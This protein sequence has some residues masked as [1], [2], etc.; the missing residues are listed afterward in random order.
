MK[1]HSLA[2]DST[3]AFNADALNRQCSNIRQRALITLIT[4]IA[5][6]LVF[7]SNNALYADETRARA[8]RSFSLVS[9]EINKLRSSAATG[10]SDTRQVMKMVQ[11]NDDAL[12][13]STAS[14]VELI[15]NA[16]STTSS[17]SQRSSSQNRRCTADIYFCNPV[18]S[19]FSA[20]DW[21]PRVY[22]RYRRRAPDIQ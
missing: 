15:G 3:R 5:I 20:L 9:D 8:T 10:E 2:V 4:L 7:F 22:K 16:I 11:E 21:Y 17:F 18:I 19:R 12:K 6:L 1:P 13:C 14:V